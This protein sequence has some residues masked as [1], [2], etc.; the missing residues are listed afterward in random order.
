MNFLSNTVKIKQHIYIL[1]AI[2]FLALILRL[3]SLWNEHWTADQQHYVSLAKK[4]SIFGFKQYN[5]K[6]IDVETYYEDRASKNF[7]IA[8]VIMEDSQ[9]NGILLTNLNKNGIFY[10]NNPL[11]H[12]PP[13]FPYLLMVSNKIFAPKKNI[14]TVMTSQQR[15]KS[16]KFPDPMIVVFQL[17][18]T[19]IPIAFSL[20]VI[21]LTYVLGKKLFSEEVGLLASLCMATNPVDIV[22][23]QK[24]MPD[25]TLSFFFCL[26]CMIFFFAY[27]KN[28]LISF[29]LSGIVAGVA[30]LFK[31]SIFFLIPSFWC[32]LVLCRYSNKKNKWE[33]LRGIVDRRLILWGIGCF[34]ICGFWFLKVYEIYGNCFFRPSQVNIIFSDTSGWFKTILNRP[35]ALLLFSVGLFC[36]SPL[37]SFYLF[38][39]NKFIRN[40]IN[41][42]RGRVWDNR[43]VFLWLIILGHVVIYLYYNGNEHRR[44]FAVY[45]FMAVLSAS[46]LINDFYRGAFLNK[47][48]QRSKRKILFII[49][50]L[51][52][53]LSIYLGLKYVGKPFHLIL[54]PF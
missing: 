49:I 38:S 36:I 11:F 28:N 53:V 40:I 46:V 34:I 51:S 30:M 29:F 13:G 39:I 15:W 2:C 21:I 17:W 37:M 26:S 7:I 43:Y 6:G 24:I 14:Y 22:I 42:F 33:W 20:G 1:L 44:L 9:S 8:P 23:S 3:P 31:E 47:L 16:Y 25:D 48:S 52:S 32:F 19:I 12:K 27:K 18:V 50:L 35:H 10:F 45:P 4:V 5:L 41:I 54:F